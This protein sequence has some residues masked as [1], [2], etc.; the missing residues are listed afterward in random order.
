MIVDGNTP[1][2]SA[3]SSLAMDLALSA[4][5][6]SEDPRAKSHF[7]HDERS[8]CYWS[9]VLL[10]N[11]YG[12]HTGT[13]SLIRD[14]KTPNIPQS[15]RAPATISSQ[16][17]DAALE[18][19]DHSNQSNEPSDLGIVAYVIELSEIWQK[20]ARYAHRRGKAGGEP[21]WSTQSDY[22]Q[23]TAEL[24][25]SETHLPYK[26]RFR[27]ARFGD[28]D[29]LQLENHRDFWASWLLLQTLYHTVLCLLNHPLLLSLRLRSFRVTMIPEVFLQHTA[30]L[31]ETHIEWILHIVDL[32]EQK[33]FELFNP[34][35]AHA[36]AIV[37]TIYLQQ[38]FSE[39]S[40]VR[41]TNQE[42]FRKCVSFVRRLGRYWPYIEQL[43]SASSLRLSPLVGWF[44]KNIYRLS[45]L[46]ALN[47][48]F[49]T[50]T[51]IRRHQD[52]RTL[53]CPLTLGCFG[54]SLSPPLSASFPEAWI[55]IS[56]RL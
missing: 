18:Q 47:K 2:A 53:E 34:F 25:L 46:N 12:N 4:G 44:L 32:C 40:T 39:D 15:P 55:L 20:A 16:M 19:P 38:S 13:V 26:Y 23:I 22:S 49:Q 52:F 29:P 3:Y 54:R 17:T 35:H 9:I 1:Q 28:Q 8:R 21:P 42:C 36:V 7:Q 43:V 14:D 56:V 27:P 51:V 37:A 10:K 30:D 24:M 31:T 45:K 41:S 6:S 11:L 50:P 33:N 48:S 5:L